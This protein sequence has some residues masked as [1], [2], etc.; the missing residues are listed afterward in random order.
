MGYQEGHLAKLALGSVPLPAGRGGS[1]R[2]RC[3]SGGRE[4]QCGGRGDVLGP[5]RSSFPS[6]TEGHMAGGLSE[7]SWA[8]GSWITDQD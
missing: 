2:D 1:S 4:S 6:V 3:Q 7:L 5:A 8:L